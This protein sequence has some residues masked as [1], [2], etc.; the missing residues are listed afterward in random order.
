V[1]PPL[2]LSPDAFDDERLGPIGREALAALVDAGES[3]GFLTVQEVRALADEGD[4]TEAE[5]EGLTAYLVEKGIEVVREQDADGSAAEQDA[6]RSY[7]SL[8][9]KFRLLSAAEEV[10][11]ARRVEHGDEAARAHLVLANLRLVAALAKRFRGQGLDMLDLVQEGTIGL[12]TAADRF[13]YRR[14]HKFSTY[15]TWWIRK[16]LFQAT[17]DQARTVRLPVHKVLDLNRILRAQRD[18]LQ[19]HGREAT[20]DEIAEHISLPAAAVRQLLHAD[21]LTIALD[22][23]LHEDDTATLADR[24][25]DDRAPSPFDAASVSLRALAL[26]RAL[27]GLPPERRR[28]IELRYGLDGSDARTLD[29]IGQLI[30]VTRDRVKE[31]ERDTLERLEVHPDTLALRDA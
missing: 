28:V 18:L 12:I 16:A 24:V 17:A 15:A 25:A 1:L 10:Q 30:G 9:G 3:R 8:I 13:D 22:A 4:V 26:R 23:P 29:E 21:R 14:G 19:R 5:L 6:L 7:Y 20:V 31:I 27:D 11:L 2:P